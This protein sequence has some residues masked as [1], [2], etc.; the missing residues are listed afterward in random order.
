MTPETPTPPPSRPGRTEPW[1]IERMVQRVPA[2]LGENTAEPVSPWMVIAGIVLLALISCGVLAFVFNLPDRL[3]TLGASVQVTRTPTLRVVTPAVTVLAPT[4]PLP[5]AT[6]AAT[7]VPIKYKVKSGDSLIAIAAKYKVTVQAI[8][9]ANGLKDETIRVGDELII[10]A[11]TS[12]PASSGGATPRAPAQSTPTPISYQAPASPSP[13]STPGTVRYTVVKGDTLIT[14]AASFGSTV[15]GIRLANQMTGDYLNVGQ[16]LLVPVGAWTPTAE[17]LAIAAVPPTPTSQ[18]TYAPPYLS[19][20]PDNQS[21]ARSNATM[22]LEWQA[23]AALKP[24]EIYL[25]HLD[26]TAD[27]QRK[28][29]VYQVSQGTSYQIKASNYP[30]A[31]EFSWYVVIVNSG[32]PSSQSSQT[33]ASA[34]AGQ[35]SAVS[36]P[37]ETH[38]FTWQ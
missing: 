25:V 38:K 22:T 8:M 11:P 5:T 1:R 23:P 2:H 28:S 12:T 20:P 13:Q 14:I 24:G 18:F 32:A 7:A 3:G 4:A 27:G 21:M 31:T 9:T 37:S 35:A 34:P 30:G 33:R 19:W 26:Y 10:P 36:P 29:A 16:V 6:A 15:D 17:P